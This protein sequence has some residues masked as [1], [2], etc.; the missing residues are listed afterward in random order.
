[1]ANISFP[2]F[3]RVRETLNL[4]FFL[5]HFALFEQTTPVALIVAS[6]RDVLLCLLAGQGDATF[7]RMLRHLVMVPGVCREK[8]TSY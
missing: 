3:T 8:K 4:G 2:I 5:V 6:R 7:D 1:M